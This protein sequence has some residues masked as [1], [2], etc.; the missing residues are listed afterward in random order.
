MGRFIFFDIDGT[1][2]HPGQAPS[3]STVKSIQTAR[4]NGHKV[5]I[6][7]GRTM[8]SIPTPIATIGFDIETMKNLVRKICNNYK[9]P[10]FT[11]SPTFSICP[12]HGYVAGEHYTC[13]SCGGEC[14]VYSRVVGYIRPITQWNKGKRQEFKDRKTFKFNE[15]SL[16]G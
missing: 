6:S 9:L 12:E 10:Y 14:E 4:R 11:F 5:F 1:L 13:P 7:T 16:C 8:D 15:E 3:E 2:A